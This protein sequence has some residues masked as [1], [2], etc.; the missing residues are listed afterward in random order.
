M[1]L[2]RREER[3]EGTWTRFVF[4]SDLSSHGV[5]STATITRTHLHGI[6]SLVTSDRNPG[7]RNNRQLKRRCVLGSSTVAPFERKIFMDI[8]WHDWEQKP[9]INRFISF[10]GYGRGGQRTRGLGDG[11]SDWGSNAVNMMNRCHQ[12]AESDV[13]PAL[14]LGVNAIANSVQKWPK[15]CRKPNFVSF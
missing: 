5:A 15:F 14:W 3:R 11:T 12:L 13:L 4:K 7:E 2:T 8:Q 1:S 9:T 6:W 10:R